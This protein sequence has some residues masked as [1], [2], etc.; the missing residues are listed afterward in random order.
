MTRISI[1]KEKITMK[2]TKITALLLALCTAFSLSACSGGTT[3]EEQSIEDRLNALDRMDEE[4]AEAALEADLEA[5][6]G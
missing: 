5:L 2:K 6:D 1:R 3:S 4:D